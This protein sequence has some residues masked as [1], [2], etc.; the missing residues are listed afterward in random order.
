MTR[1]MGCNLIFALMLS[2]PKMGQ[3]NMFLTHIY[4][5]DGRPDRR[6]PGMGRIARYS[7]GEDY[8][9]VIRARLEALA[10]ELATIGEPGG[11]HLEIGPQ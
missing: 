6:E 10:Q 11:A 1:F 7:R 8:H 4:Y 2:A 9:V 3:P 5:A